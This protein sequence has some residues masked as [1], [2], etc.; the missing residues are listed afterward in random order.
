MLNLAHVRSF[1]TIIDTKGV[2]SAAKALELA[3]STI[4]EHIKQLEQD[5]AA[6]LL[7][8]KYGAARPT[9]P[10]LRF[11]PYARAWVGTASRVKDLIH[12][13]LL[14]LAA[15]SNVGIYL[16]QPRI[17]DFRRQTGI[18]VEMWIG[19]NPQVAERLERGE[20][21]VA[22][23]EWWDDRA[24]FAASTWIRE[25]LVVIV[26]PDHPWAAL[27]A[28]APEE[29]PNEILLGGEPGSGTGRVLR[30]QLGAVA[31]RLHTRSGLGSTEAVKRAVQAGHGVSIVMNSSVA[32]EVANG[33]LVALPIEGASL[34][35]NI[36]LVV[37]DLLPSASPAARL[38]DAC[39][40]EGTLG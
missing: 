11:L 26:A 38:V 13:P 36:K 5:L 1:L 16:L 21:D 33:R 24:G 10:G 28:I 18:E 14:R 29:L 30:E 22:A 19:P 27:Q 20:A 17:A 23:M 34:V 6:P 3:P 35:K 12:Q 9:P 8:R 15:A 31:E 39:C 40:T 4:V 25:S 7:V 2:R 37:A 32:D